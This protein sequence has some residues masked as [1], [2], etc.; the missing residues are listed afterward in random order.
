M[1]ITP[2]PHGVIVMPIRVAGW[3]SCMYN[4]TPTLPAALLLPPTHPHPHYPCCLKPAVP[5]RPSSGGPPAPPPSRRRMM[6]TPA[7][8]CKSTCSSCGR[9]TK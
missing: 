7:G 6:W 1:V 4:P 2:H 9:S 8:A 3:H 5:S